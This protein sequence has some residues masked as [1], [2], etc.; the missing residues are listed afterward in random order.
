LKHPYHWKVSFHDEFAPEFDGFP[1]DV[2]DELLA[3]AAAVQELGFDRHLKK[4]KAASTS[5]LGRTKSSLKK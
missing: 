3:A 2:Q 1:E 4:L 5:T